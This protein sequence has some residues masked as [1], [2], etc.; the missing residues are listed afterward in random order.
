MS[1][2]TEQQA[3]IDRLQSEQ[4]QDVSPEDRHAFLKAI[5]SVPKEELDTTPEPPKEKRGPKP[6]LRSTVSA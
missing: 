4:R 2:T 3:A 6:A 5:V 1:Q